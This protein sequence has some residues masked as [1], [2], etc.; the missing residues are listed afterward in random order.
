V[1]GEKNQPPQKLPEFTKLGKTSSEKKLGTSTG[2][3]FYRF[4]DL[5]KILAWFI[6]TRLLSRNG[7]KGGLN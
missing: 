5:N 6:T 3:I 2:V 4:L 7:N 1:F